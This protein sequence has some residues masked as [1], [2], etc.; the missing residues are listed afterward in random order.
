[1]INLTHM[2]FILYFIFT[3]VFYAVYMIEFSTL[4]SEFSTFVFHFI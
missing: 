1:M 4:S 3:F 2:I